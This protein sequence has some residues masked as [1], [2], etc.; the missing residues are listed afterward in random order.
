MK[1]K[2]KY[3]N[4]ITYL[5]GIRFQSKLEADRYAQ[6][7]LM[8]MGK[9]IKDLELQPKFLL[10]EGFIKNGQTFRPIYYSADFRYWCNERRRVI[11]EDTKGIKTREFIVSQKIFEARYPDLQLEI[12]TAKDVY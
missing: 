4:I 11:V 8:Q 6:L 5:D 7:K 12:I 3:G 2:N 10:Q 9:M 1:K